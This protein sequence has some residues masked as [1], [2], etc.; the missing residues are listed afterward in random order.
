[1]YLL[2]RILTIFGLFLTILNTLTFAAEKE[3]ITITATPDKEEVFIGDRINVSVKTNLKKNLQLSFPEKIS[4]TGD[5]SFIE[6]Q[7]IK[8]KFG[9]NEKGIVYILG[10][11]STGT[12][13][14]PPIKVEYRYSDKDTWQ[15]IETR[16]IPINVKSIL[17]GG[18]TDI[19]DI[20]GPIKWHSKIYRVC[21]LISII[22]IFLIIV[23]LFLKLK[24][25]HQ[26]FI[27]KLK[28]RPAHIIAYEEL[29]NLKSED[30][31]RKGKIKEYYFSLSDI[32]R[33]YIEN[34]FKYR[35]PEMTT[36]EFLTYIKQEGALN[37]E[38]RE[39]LK[40][41]LMQCDMVKFAKYGPTP[42]EIIDSFKLAE[43]FVN[44]TKEE[45]ENNESAKLEKSQTQKGV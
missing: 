21:L 34:R 26:D 40:E 33:H 36:E 4:E 7:P 44:E 6:A 9:K 45:P 8:T 27:E 43:T 20:K 5:F 41:F 1:M 10:I 22:V 30:L 12:H 14:I 32:V 35:A 17:K 23:A 15:T 19:R 39:L 13:V 31:P 2:K 3:K 24:R 18:E 42:I 28:I 11:Y 37:P 16:Q 25:L 29:S 38:Q